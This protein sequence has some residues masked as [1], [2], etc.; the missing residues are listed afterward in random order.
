MIK[1]RITMALG[2]LLCVATG[3]FAQT[4]QKDSTASQVE[5]QEVVIQA[6]KVIHKADMDVYQ[7]SQSAID[8][9]KN[10]LQLLHHLTIPSL[11]VNEVLGTITTA[12]QSVQIRINGRIATT[13]QVKELPPE[14][15]KRVEWIE[16]P[17]LRYNGAI[18]V[19]NV[20]VSNP[21]VGGS[22]M[23]EALPALNTAW[24][25]Y[26]TA[27]KLNNGR[28]QWGAS[29]NFKNTNHLGSHRDYI[30]TFTKPDGTSETRTEK[31][32]YGYFSDNFGGVQLDYTYNKPDTTTFWIAIHGYKQWPDESLYHS[33]LSLN[34]GNSDILLHDYMGNDGFT[35]SVRTYF[36]QHFKHNQIIAIDINGSFYTGKTA[37]SYV[38]RNAETGTIV[39]DANL[40]I[41]DRNKAYGATADYIKNWSASRLTVGVS[42]TS[43]RNQSTYENL[44]GQVFNQHQDAVYFYGE[45]FHKLKKFTFTG[46]LGA[47]YNSFYFLETGQGNKSWNLRPQ[48][49]ITYRHGDVSSFNL[50]LTSWQR[51]PTLNETNI[52]EQQID[53]FQWQ[54][55]NP[56]LKTSSSYSLT[57][58]YNFNLPRVT[59]QFGANILNS[60]NAIAPFYEWEGNRLIKSF[61]NS[62]GLN[63][64]MFWLSPEIEVI[65]D[66][67][68]IEGTLRY[69]NE[70]TKGRGYNV[71]HHNWSGDATAIITHWGFN[72]I[73]NYEK[74]QTSLWG[75]KITFDESTSLVELQYNWRDW[76][77][78]LGVL[79]PFNKYD[80]GSILLN[81][82]NSNEYHLRIDM[83]P[84]PFLRINYNLQWGRQ[85][86]GLKKLVTTDADIQQSSAAGR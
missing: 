81:K 42:Y 3:A 79:C 74:A 73:I 5:L 29:I 47:Q 34:N 25:Q 13:Q 31:P 32:I 61:E 44:D 58:R 59:G 9:S 26:S 8:N 45:Y 20:I 53:G 62:A 49:T 17:G 68:I 55:G 18:A 23:L 54:R 39:T 51:T 38:E 19:L 78:G 11:S 80:Q 86:H 4:E 71:H 16:N 27:L 22:F 28:S 67:L 36:E 1:K 57:F 48:A 52:V 84:M 14:T 12:G 82:W 66:W 75:E 76:Q 7:P 65:P 40:L 33:R 10:S 6:P 30:E 69:K 41:K 56:D 63:S 85:K 70:R 37:R 64:H 50:S 83:A 35:P 77:F 43:R 46:G 15:V 72:L 21:T 24:G 2:A 60:P